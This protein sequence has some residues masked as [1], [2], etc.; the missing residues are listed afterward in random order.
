MDTRNHPF[1][2]GV[3]FVGGRIRDE[4][5]FVAVVCNA[6][7]LTQA[8]LGISIAPLHIIGDSFGASNAQLS[9][10]PAAYSLT[11]GS[12]IL[13]AGR[14][15]DLFGHRRMFIAGWLWFALWSLFAGVAVYS[16]QIFFDVCRALQ[17]MGPA[18]LLPNALAI[19]GRTY[20]PGRRKDMVFSIFGA[21]APGGFL[22]GAVFSSMLAQLAWWP[23]GYWILCIYCILL[24][25]ASFMVIPSDD[26]ITWPIPKERFDIWGTTVGVAGLMFLNVAWNQAGVVGWQEPY[27]YVF[28]VLGVLLLGL[29]VYIEHKVSHPLLELRKFAVPTLYILACLA[30]GWGCFGIW[31]YYSWQIFEVL[32]HATPLLACAWYAPI[33]VSGLCAAM[34]TGFL[35]ARV[36]PIMIMLIAMAA[37]FVGSTLVAF[38]SIEQN[39]WAQAFIANIIMP[40]GMDMSFPSGTILL[41]NSMPREQQG[42]AASVVNTVVNYSISLSLGIAGTIERNVNQGGNDVSKGYHGALYLAMGLSGLGLVVALISLLRETASNRNVG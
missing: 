15:G 38:M 16:D 12:F 17:G 20:P 3:V 6:Q 14:L 13:F 29:F 35:L 26:P 4:V 8:G 19:L 9:W 7:L 23:W 28:L 34:T 39:Y 41:S 30:V 22:L 40:W 24:S 37:F 31:V 32:R 33:A 10:F 5:I 36:K 25:G 21:T 2:G 27:T 42:M 11:V 1:L 18:V